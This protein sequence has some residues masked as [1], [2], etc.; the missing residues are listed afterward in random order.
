MEIRKMTLEDLPQVMAL[1]RECFQDH[2]DIE[3]YRYEIEENSFSTMLV[4]VEHEELLGA[5][6]YYILFEEG[7]I[8]TIATNPAYR[9]RG[10]ASTMM[11]VMLADM[12]VHDCET[13]SLEVRVHN[14][15]AIH[16]YEKFG[17]ITVNVRKGYYQDGEDAYLMVK[18]IGG[19]NHENLSD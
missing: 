8:T 14:E 4:A 5:C 13:C 9:G 15:A 19:L 6:G 7:Q 17:F 12:V 3:A 18:A 10:I 2:W 1:E 11:E 16:L